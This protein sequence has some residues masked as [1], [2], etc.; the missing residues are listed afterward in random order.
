MSTRGLAAR[1]S[2]SLRVARWGLIGNN[3]IPYNVNI[4]PHSHIGRSLL[5]CMALFELSGN[6][7]A[8]RCGSPSILLSLNQMNAS[9]LG[10][11][12]LPPKS[13]SGYM[14]LMFTILFTLSTDRIDF[15][16]FGN[17]LLI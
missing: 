10:I 4:L 13:C 7:Y 14:P 5:N 9:K 12:L 17:L 3:P 1:I 11:L 6:F 8:V 2:L 15:C 16:T